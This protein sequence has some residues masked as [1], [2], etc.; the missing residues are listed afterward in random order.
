[1]L[2]IHRLVLKTSV[3]PRCDCWVV[4]VGYGVR[5]VKEFWHG[6]CCCRYHRSP[7][8]PSSGTCEGDTSQM[9]SPEQWSWLE[10]E[11]AKPSAVK[12]IGTCMAVAH[13][14]HAFLC[15]LLIQ[16]KIAGGSNSK[17]WIMKCHSCN[18]VCG[19]RSQAVEFRCCRR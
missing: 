9:L 4:V 13:G 17:L 3:T 15:L 14:N 1:M 5:S 8:Y 6:Y 16:L 18:L 19:F 12:I 11:L 2:I 10:A 7:V